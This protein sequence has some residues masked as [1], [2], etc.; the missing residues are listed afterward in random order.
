LGTTTAI[1]TEASNI[2][3]GHYWRGQAFLHLGHP[4]NARAEF[5]A[6]EA[7][8]AHFA[9]AKAAPERLP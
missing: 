2:E 4:D 9:L 1:L 6:A 7:L 5:S 8:N 3:E